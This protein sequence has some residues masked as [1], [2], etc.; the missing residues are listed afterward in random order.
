MSDLIFRLRA[1]DTHKPLKARL[2]YENE[3]G[4]IQDEDLSSVSGVKFSMWELGHDKKVV[5][6]QDAT[7]NVTGEGK[8]QYGFSSS[9]VGEPGTYEGVF[10]VIYSD[11]SEETWPEGDDNVIIVIGES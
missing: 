10:T 3:S 6:R 2:Q 8:V 7:I 5:D 4:N 9:E 1:G 11:N